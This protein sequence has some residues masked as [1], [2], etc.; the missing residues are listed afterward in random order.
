MLDDVGAPVA[1]EHL[2]WCLWFEQNLA[3]RIVAK[4]QVGPYLVSTVFLGLDHNFG[5][6]PPV[7]WE[8]MVFHDDRGSEDLE[9]RRYASQQ[10]ALEGHAAMVATVTATEGP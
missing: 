7:L 10:D 9:C 4:S 6:G 5:D 1:V 2:A 3:R 8:T